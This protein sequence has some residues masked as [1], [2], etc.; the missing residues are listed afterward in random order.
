MID[1]N[2]GLH[3]IKLGILFWNLQEKIKYFTIK[4]M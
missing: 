3:T 2:E 1:F 4:N